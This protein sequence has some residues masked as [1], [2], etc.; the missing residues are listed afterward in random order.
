ML[1]VAGGYWQLLYFLNTGRTRVIMLMDTNNSSLLVQHYKLF[2]K[3][4]NI[5][6]YFDCKCDYDHIQSNGKHLCTLIN[7]FYFF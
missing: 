2:L 5:L 3:C 4:L 1:V 6:I 7:I